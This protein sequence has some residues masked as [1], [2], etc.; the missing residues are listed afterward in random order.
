MCL[1]GKFE[2]KAY[3]GAKFGI[4]DR[5]TIQMLCSQSYLKST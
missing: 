4:N 1:E 3:F 5:Q 2:L